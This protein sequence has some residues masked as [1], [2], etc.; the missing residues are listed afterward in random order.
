MPRTLSRKTL[1]LKNALNSSCVNHFVTKSPL[2]FQYKIAF[3][4]GLSNFL[5]MLIRV[6]KMLFKNLKKL[7]EAIS[8]YE[9][10]EITFIEVLN[11]HAP[12]REKLLRANLVPYITKILRKAIMCRS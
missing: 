9:S 7:R 1:V 2:S 8:N 5:K 4:D 11:K 3:S 10:F 12:L 6:I